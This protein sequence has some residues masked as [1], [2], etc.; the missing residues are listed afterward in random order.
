MMKFRILT[1]ALLLGLALPAAADFTTIVE[2][3]EVSI[4][5]VRLPQTQFGTIAYKRC[6]T[7]RYETKRVAGD[8][9]LEINGEKL[10]LDDFRRQLAEIEDRNWVITLGHHLQRDEIIRV[11]VYLP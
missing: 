3:Y 5:N 11:T 1:T 7:C 10:R 2:G 9:S 4:K 6:D 8:V